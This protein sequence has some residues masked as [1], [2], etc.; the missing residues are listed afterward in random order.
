M[1]NRFSKTVTL[2]ALS[3]LST[4]ALADAP[5]RVGRIALTQGQVGISADVG[6]E[7]NTALINWPVTSHNQITTARGA[8]TEVRVGSTAIR[9][10]GDSALEIVELDDDS[11]RLHLHYG[12]VSVR[13]RNP[14]VLPGFELSTPQGRVRLQEPGRVRVDA[15]R[16]PDT[17]VVSVFDGVAQVEGAGASLTVRAGRS[18]ELH[19][20][21]LRTALAGRDSFD[22]WAML[23]D[24]QDER[25][26]AER[27]VTSE[28]TGY[29]D[30]DRYGIWRD[31]SEYG[32]LWIP[33][34]VPSDWVPYRDGRWTY[35]EPWGWTWVDNA[36]WGYAP[37]HYGRW[38]V[39]NQR[40]CWAPGR[41]IGRPVWAPALVGW[42]GGAGWSLNFAT[43]GGHHAAP[44]QGWYPLAPREAFVPG[45]HLSQD[46]L[47]YINRHARDDDR[48]DGRDEHRRGDGRRD[49]GRRD[50]FHHQGLTVVPQAQFGQRGSL[51]VT[52]APKAVVSQLALQ[53]VPMAAP[54]APQG[55]PHD[56]RS[57]PARGER[58]DNG[59][60]RHDGGNPP[61]QAEHRGDGR[62]D[63]GRRDGARND[64]RNDGRAD[65]RNDGRDNARPG[66]DPSRFAG[67]RYVTAPQVNPV[68]TQQQGGWAGAGRAA[69]IG[70]RGA[71]QG[72]D[73]RQRQRVATPQPQAVPQPAPQAAPLMAA[74]AAVA[75]PPQPQPQRDDR[76]GRMQRFEEERRQREFDLSSAARRAMAPPR[77]VPEPQAAMPRPTPMPPPPQ[78]VMPR[79]MP[80]PQPQPQPQPQQQPAMP[81]PMPMP[82]Q[83]VQMAR[84]APAPAP[85][86]HKEDGGRENRERGDRGDR[87]KT[88]TR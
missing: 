36:P 62:R 10:D 33:R 18:A 5:T 42:V 68:P 56:G 43:R 67:S 71:R 27:Y 3:V 4:L 46:H 23:R 82:Q 74:P 49:D 86:A 45:Y 26:V 6:E 80:M 61:A 32:P 13:V 75:Q 87:G 79:P 58:R 8:R 85:A 73:E 11:L 76:V 31:D 24:R 20:D 81:R 34:N 12:S 41:D 7:S 25:A 55:V 64:G 78:Q 63:D 88:E 53:R 59:G 51:L 72:E 37:F 44:A 70:E 16:A 39:I 66:P 84:P 9:L 77:P 50:G 60:E 57:I 83:Q 22:D 28:M 21:D 40:W 65:P 15:E 52:Q 35:L 19:D 48:R 1:S 14:D 17:S 29:E 38:V 30:L 47:R 54:P 2:L 69:V